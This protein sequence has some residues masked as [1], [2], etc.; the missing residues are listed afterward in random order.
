VL[1]TGKG[2]D[3]VRIF[4]DLLPQRQRWSEKKVG[5]GEGLLYFV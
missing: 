3:L 4:Y 5:G 1:L 2:L